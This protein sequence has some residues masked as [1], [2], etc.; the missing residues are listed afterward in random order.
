MRRLRTSLAALA[1]IA[2]LPVA[3][4][5]WRQI[6][7]EVPLARVLP[8]VEAAV[9]KN[10]RDA[11][12]RYV[13]GRLH[14]LA[15]ATDT[16][17]IPV[18]LPEDSPQG[19]SLPGFAPYRTI[20]VARSGKALVEPHRTH[21]VK[22]LEHYRRAVELAPNNPLYRLGL[23]WML[24]SAAPHVNGL[25]P[26]SWAPKVKPT[27]V[28]I[29]DAALDHYRRVVVLQS[30]EDL[31]A[32]HLRPGEDTQLSK[33]A[34]QGIVR[35]LN[36]RTK[37]RQDVRET[38][39]MNA[40]AA[41]LA[42]IP[43]PITPI[44]LPLEGETS[45]PELLSARTTQFDLAGDGTARTWPWV[46][47]STGILV[48]DPNRTGKVTSGRQ[49]FGTSTWWMFFRDGYA[50]LATL[51]ADGDGWLRGTET[52]GISIWRDANENG[53]SDDGEVKP[54]SH[55]RIAELSVRAEGENA[56]GPFN[57]RGVKR[58]DGTYTP[59][60]DWVPVSLAK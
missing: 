43:R 9:R 29:E 50:A 11:N 40:L 24:E 3:G 52:H 54:L 37:T 41:K 36:G 57:H 7:R 46:K 21:L 30:E 12:A 23:A 4:A 44:I 32:T 51:D 27:R 13:L 47:S 20:L 59:T 17:T 49:L 58:T 33:E 18:V 26:F 48:W 25:K 39:R 16:R 42:K 15:F 38:T 2:L 5:R 55:W 1:L 6:D 31:K 19:N 22:S 56:T 53:R 14:S 28:V 45:L 60:F 8:N 34:A 10:P 35:V